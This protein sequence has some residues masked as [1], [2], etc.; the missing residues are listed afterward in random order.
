MDVTGVTR[1]VPRFLNRGL[2]PFTP[3][4]N[5]GSGAF[6]HFTVGADRQQ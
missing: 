6:E 4:L 5:D 2:H 3:E 1:S